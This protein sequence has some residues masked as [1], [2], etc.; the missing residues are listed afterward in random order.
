[1]KSML[2]NYLIIKRFILKKCEEV[3][4][5][6]DYAEAQKLSKAGYDLVVLDTTQCDIALEELVE[7]LTSNGTKVIILSEKRVNLNDI[8]DF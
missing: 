7:L 8:K 3:T 6:I 5:K 2:L 1:M 4:R